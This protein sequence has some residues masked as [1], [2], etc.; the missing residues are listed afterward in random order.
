MNFLP[1]IRW[2]GAFDF[3]ILAV[4]LYALL[5]WARQARA[6]RI[7]VGVAGLHGG[8]LA[9][10]YLDLTITSWVLDGTAI[11]TV[12]LLLV[13]FQSELRHA[14]LRFDA[15]LRLRPQ[16]PASLPKREQMIAQAAFALAQTGVGALF[17]LARRDTVLELS[18]GGLLLDA[19]V[20]TELLVAL[21]QKLSPLHD[22]AAVV[23]GDRIS[24]AGVVLP[25]TDRTDIPA[26]YGTR[27]RAALGLAE[28]CDA[29]VIAVSEERRQVTLVEGRGTRLMPSAAE[30]AAAL[31]SLE[32]RTT[33]SLSGRLR[34]A[35]TAHLGF[36][37]AALGLAGLFWSTSVLPTTV[38]TISAPV[39]F[40]RV[41]AGMQIVS[42][43]ADTLEVQVR[44]NGWIMDSLSLRGLVARFD[45]SRARAGRLRLE[46]KARAF[47]LPPGVTV[48]QVSPRSVSVDLEPRR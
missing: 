18:E 23:R 28:R 43:S 27:H 15:V 5:R 11:V 42:Q 3:V 36:K 4:A 24:R 44:G 41:P 10:R 8:A 25:L 17:V 26:F 30:L 9:A 19:E 34:H 37:F 22:G 13:V 32:N 12:L 48:D 6:L 35:F 33:L 29:L 39:E 31:R 40:A 7:A 46:V 1:S 16:S 20:S 47:D 14:L 21:F 2:Q 45:L 38:R